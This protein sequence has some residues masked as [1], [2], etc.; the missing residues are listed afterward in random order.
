MSEDAIKLVS[1]ASI[2]PASVEQLLDHAFGAD[3]KARTAYRL[4]EGAPVLDALSFAAIDSDGT[5]L[6]TVQCW[7]VELRGDDGSVLPLTMLGPVA[8]EPAH[9]RGG[10]GRLLTAAALAAAD[11]AGSPPMMLIGDPEYYGR[12][13]GFSAER[14]VGW[15]LPGPVERHRLLARGDDLPLLSGS[16]GPRLPITA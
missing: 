10:I 9:Q 7:P 6:G 1:L 5:L 15:R 12:F 2:A 4:R 3:R 11:A 8:V 14:T 13:F 16:I